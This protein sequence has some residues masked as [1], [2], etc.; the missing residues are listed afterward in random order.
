MGTN[1]HPGSNPLFLSEVDDGKERTMGVMCVMT[2]AVGMGVSSFEGDGVGTNE[3]ISDE[4]PSPWPKLY[5]LEVCND[6]KDVVS[7]DDGVRA[8]GSDISPA[9]PW[10]DGPLI[11]YSS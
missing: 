8:S 3:N 4:N 6:E 11:P 9:L 2:S 10:L 5:D 7:S 1:T